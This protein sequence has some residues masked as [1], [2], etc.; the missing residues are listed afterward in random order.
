[1]KAVK[2]LTP[3]VAIIILMAV[4]AFRNTA[5]SIKGWVTPKE[6]GVAA[7][8]VSKTD[9]FKTHITSEGVFEIFE[10]KP[11]T[12]NVVVQAASPYKTANKDAVVVTEGSV[13]DIGEIKLE[14]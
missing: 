10:V 1:M 14:K 12:Y 4:F 8:A 11:G 9:T 3:L 13:V 7:W 5:S 6:A 2:F